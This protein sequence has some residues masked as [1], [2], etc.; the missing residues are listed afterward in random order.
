MH[1]IS[2]ETLRKIE[3]GR[4][5]SSGFF[6]VPAIA[7]TLGVSLDEMAERARTTNPDGSRQVAI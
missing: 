7:G 6:T 1:G 3:G 5:P 4:I 2:V